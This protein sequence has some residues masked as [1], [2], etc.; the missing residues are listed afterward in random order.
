MALV[1]P[2][3]RLL[4]LGEDAETF[5]KPIAQ[6]VAAFTRRGKPALAAARLQFSKAVRGNLPIRVLEQ[7][8]W[9]FQK[10]AFAPLPDEYDAA[11][12]YLEGSPIYFCADFV[13]AKRKIAV[14]HSDYRKLEL[15]AAFDDAYFRAFDAIV[16]VSDA[17]ADVLRA[18]FPDKAD[19][20]QVIENIVSP[21]A[22]HAQSTQGEAAD[23]R[24]TGLRVLTMGRLDAPKGID[25]AVE[26]A[27]KLAD[28]FDFRWYVLG[29]GAQ[30]DA[31]QRQ[32]DACGLGDR[33][34]LAGAKLN[35]YPDLARCDV[36][37]QPS[38]F[39]GKSIALEE[40]KCL[41]RPILTTAFTTVRDQIEDGK[42][43]VIAQIDAGDIAQKLRT[44][45]A[46][47]ALRQRLSDTLCGYAGS[48]C[49]IKKWE[50]LWNV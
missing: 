14:I 4:K 11:V 22:L 3:V 16:A 8:G 33:F 37:V 5:S 34:I 25:L 45:L 31:L 50:T 21:A 43:G 38:R 29:E 18:V 27:S 2:E 26:A 6:A 40:A 20:V 41:Q 7:R 24:Y 46:D 17:C 28:A 48:V 47:P 19:R 13:R 1:P 39:E 30:R 9:K 23:A 12:A 15:D 44:L 42:T 36:Y 49:E 35:P 10:K 32:I